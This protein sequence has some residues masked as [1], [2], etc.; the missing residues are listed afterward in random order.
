M[1]QSHFMVLARELREEL[2]IALTSHHAAQEL[3]ERVVGKLAQIQHRVTGDPLTDGHR[4]ALDTRS[5]AGAD[6]AGEHRSVEPA[7]D[8]E[9]DAEA[10]L[11]DLLTSA[12]KLHQHANGGRARRQAVDLNVDVAQLD[13]IASELRRTVTRVDDAVPTGERP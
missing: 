11:R 2:Q 3:V 1:Q 9:V 4:D 8:R 12:T 10:V 13:L 7:G 5:F 6:L